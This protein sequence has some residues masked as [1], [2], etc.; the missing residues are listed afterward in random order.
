MLKVVFYEN[1]SNTVQIDFE[2]DDAVKI[3]YLR[4]GNLEPQIR[5][6]NDIFVPYKVIQAVV[7]T[8]EG[9]EIVLTL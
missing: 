8:V 4:E 2:T 9:G 3:T 7:D 6:E 5:I 1:V